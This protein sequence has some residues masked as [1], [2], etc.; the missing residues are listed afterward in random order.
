MW[1]KVKRFLSL[2]GKKFKKPYIIVIE[3]LDGAGKE[4][5]TNA[6][7]DLLTNEG[8]KVKKISFPMYD[9]WHSFL[10]RWF[11][12][13]KFGNSPYSVSPRIASL[14]YSIDRFFGYHFSIV[15]DLKTEEEQTGE[16]YDFII[17]DRYTTASMLYQGAKEDNRYHGI[18]VA[19]FIEFVEYTLFR[20]PRPNKI[21]VLSST[22]EQ[23]KEAM[24]NR[25]K[26]DVNEADLAYQQNVRKFLNV[27]IDYYRWFPIAT[28]HEDP[29]YEW[30]D[31]K[32]IA[33]TMYDHIEFYVFASIKLLK[34][35]T[36]MGIID[37][38]TIQKGE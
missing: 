32:D 31:P 12:K 25:A 21:F 34:K 15:Q 22:A 20:L 27:L 2:W 6:L 9:R 4:T 19:K 23:S 16:P 7:H 8:Y 1:K 38:I 29:P 13:G 5:S 35:D 17:F 24:K 18:S 3:G 33:Q 28:R 37:S 11:L 26:L 10:V 14:F 30:Y 36:K